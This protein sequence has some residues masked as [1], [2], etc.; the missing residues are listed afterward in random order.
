[1]QNIYTPWTTSKQRRTQL[2]PRGWDATAGCLLGCA[3]PCSHPQ[4]RDCHPPHNPASAFLHSCTTQ[5]W[6]FSSLNYPC[7]FKKK[8]NTTKLTHW[9]TTRMTGLEEPVQATPPHLLG[10]SHQPPTEAILAVPAMRRGNNK[11]CEQPRET[12]ILSIV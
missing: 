1:M 6:S 9:A 10:K 2:K 4:H 5:H 12:F 11:A 7:Y 8:Q 3:W